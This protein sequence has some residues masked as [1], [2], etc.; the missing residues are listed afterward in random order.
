MFLVIPEVGSYIRL[1]PFEVMRPKQLYDFT[2]HNHFELALVLVREKQELYE[3]AE[4][5]LNELI[6]LLNKELDR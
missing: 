1:N 5:D 2:F 6:G 4:K 3:Q